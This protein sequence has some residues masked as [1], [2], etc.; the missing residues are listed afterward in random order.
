MSRGRIDLVASTAFVVLR[1]SGFVGADL[2]TRFTGADT[3]LAWRYVIAAAVLWLVLLVR[4]TRI[5]R[6]AVRRQGLLGVLIQVLY[7]GGVVTGVGLGVPAGT[8]ALIAACSRWSSRRRPGR[9]SASTRP[10]RQRIGLAGGLVGVAL[11]VAGDLGPGDAPWWAFVLPVGGM[12]AL[13]AGTLLERRMRPPES[14]LVA[15]TLQAST[16]AV[17][18]G[19]VA[20]AAGDVTPPADPGFWGAIVWVVLLSSFGGYGSYL[21]VLR[22]SGAT[23]VSTLLYLTPPTTMAWTFLMFGEVPV[24]LA[25]PGIALCAL[26]VWLVL[27]TPR[28]RTP[29]AARGA[30]CRTPGASWGT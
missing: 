12:L 21:L 11:V 29:Q 28:R 15:M 14:P 22:R 23:R 17:L 30:N 18:F 5:P 27:G 3:L 4:R 25:A 1:S 6:G 16:A 24:P 19:A 10:P 9:S 13:S 26:G 7:L 2:G 8:A 20:V